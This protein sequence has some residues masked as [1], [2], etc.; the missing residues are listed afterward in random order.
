MQ[1]VS[2]L[3]SQIPNQ[4]SSILNPQT[5]IPRDKKKPKDC[6]SIPDRRESRFFIGKEGWREHGLKEAESRDSK[7]YQFQYQFANLQ[8]YL[9]NPKSKIPNQK[10]SILPS[11]S[12]IKNPQ[13]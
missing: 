2:I 12:Q 4:K 3:I 10:Y 11:Q 8:S 7:K 1:F 6:F 9:F 5:Q 13:S